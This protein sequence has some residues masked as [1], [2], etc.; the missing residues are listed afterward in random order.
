MNKLIGALLAAAAIGCVA[1]PA[2]AHPDDDDENV[3]PSYGQYYGGYQNFDAAYGASYAT[4]NAGIYWQMTDATKI[5]LRYSDTALSQADCGALMGTAGTE[6][7][8]KVMLSL[9][10]DLAASDLGG[11]N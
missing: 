2:L 1:G 7:G 11:G 9:S 6:C 4:W 8:A 5:D 10:V 3:N